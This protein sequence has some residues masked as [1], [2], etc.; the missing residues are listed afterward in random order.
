M[1]IDEILRGESK[2]IEYKE[3]VPSNSR[4]YTRTAAAYAN[5]AGGRIVFGVENN[6]WKIIGIP[7]EKVFEKADSISNAIMDSCEPMI[8]F[9]IMYQ[10]IERKF[11]RDYVS[12]CAD[13]MPDTGR[14]KRC[15]ACFTK[16][17]NFMGIAGKTGR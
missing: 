3:D 6:T 4:K 1:T 17:F 13:E 10:T 15:K 8:D 9:D 12:I 16:K 11:M 2:E 5:C 7:Q 14:E